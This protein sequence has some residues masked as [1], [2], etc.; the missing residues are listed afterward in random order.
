MITDLV[1]NHKLGTTSVNAST[2]NRGSQP[3][4]REHHGAF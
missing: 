4:T 3:D 1:A 2:Y